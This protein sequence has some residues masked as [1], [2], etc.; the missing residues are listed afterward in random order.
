MILK[1][2]VIDFFW[3]ILLHNRGGK[4]MKKLVGVKKEE[5]ICERVN[6]N[7]QRAG[8]TY[9]TSHLQSASIE[10]GDFERGEKNGERKG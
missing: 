10:W 6:C 2:G 8:K 3:G 1:H 9:P 5:I 7:G 4:E